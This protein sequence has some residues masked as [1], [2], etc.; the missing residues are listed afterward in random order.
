[1]KKFMIAAMA[2]TTSVC[3]TAQTADATPADTATTAVT[4]VIAKDQEKVEIK[5]EELP[6]AIQK[7]LA[8]D[9]FKGWAVKTAYVVKSEKPFYEVALTN[10][11]KEN[12]VVQFNEDGSIIQ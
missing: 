1:M 8:S 10:Q 5:A 4:T 7:V 6:V 11:A 2:L 12:K 9:S 3:A